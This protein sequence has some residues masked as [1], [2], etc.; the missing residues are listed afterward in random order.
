MSEEDDLVMYKTSYY[1]SN[2]ATRLTSNQDDEEQ[3]DEIQ[4]GSR[5]KAVITDTNTNEEGITFY[6]IKVEPSLKKSYVIEKRY[7]DFLNL[8]NELIKSNP[9]LEQVPFPAKSYLYKNAPETIKERI[10]AFNGYLEHILSD[11]KLSL[12]PEVVKFINPHWF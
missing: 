11:E 2:I 10:D 6:H 7:N 3:S 4:S 12:I 8:H 1:P 5:T 9:E